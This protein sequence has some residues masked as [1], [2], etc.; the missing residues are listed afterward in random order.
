MADAISRIFSSPE[1]FLKISKISQ[2]P[3]AKAANAAAQIIKFALFTRKSMRIFEAVLIEFTTGYK[4]KSRGKLKLYRLGG[5]Q[6]LFSSDWAEEVLP[7]LLLTPDPCVLQK[8]I[9]NLSAQSPEYLP[10]LFHYPAAQ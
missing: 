8:Q 1:S 9:L 6:E 3:Y 7:E 5:E 10:N 2:K 4:D